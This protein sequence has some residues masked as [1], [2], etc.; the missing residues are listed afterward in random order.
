MSTSRRVLRRTGDVALT[1]VALVGLLSLL[2]WGAVQVGWIKPLVVVSGSMEP[3]IMTGDLVVAVPTPTAHL[4]VGDVATI[5]NDVT[6][7]L[8][9]HR[10]VA[11][12]PAADGA[13]WEVRMKGDAN[14]SEDGGVYV[15][16]DQVWTP[17]WQLGGVGYVLAELTRPAVAVPL[18]V[19]VGCLVGLALLPRTPRP[20]SARSAAPREVVAPG[21]T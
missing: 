18:V 11:V 5:H 1:L 20:G 19:A 12:E 15:V 2:T 6:G 4:E 21:A 14:E 8:V 7:S 17:R 10:V 3:G 9:T 16:G 13:T